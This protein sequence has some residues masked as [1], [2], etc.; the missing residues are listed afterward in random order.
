MTTYSLL[1]VHRTNDDGTIDGG[2]LQDHV[3]TLRSARQRAAETSAANSGMP[4][5]VVA[6]VGFC[7]PAEVFTA[8][9]R[10]A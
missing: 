2:W 7:G 10:L 5:A 6:A 3:G 8:Q 9:R 4:I 1:T